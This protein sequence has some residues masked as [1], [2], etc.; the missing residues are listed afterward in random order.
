MLIS[1]AE[2]LEVFHMVYHVLFDAPTPALIGPAAHF[3]QLAHG[4]AQAGGEDLALD[5]RLRFDAGAED[6]CN[7]RA[8]IE[9]D[10]GDGAAVQIENGRQAVVV[11]GDTGTWSTGS[12]RIMASSRCRVVMVEST[13]DIGLPPECDACTVDGARGP[14]FAIAIPARAAWPVQLLSIDHDT[15]PKCQQVLPASPPPASPTRHDRRS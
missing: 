6:G 9:V 4:R 1:K 8:G 10:G 7:E 5:A 11:V 13:L 15:Y 3:T 12:W 14:R 2:D